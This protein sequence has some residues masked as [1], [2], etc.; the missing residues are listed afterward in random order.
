MSDREP[1]ISVIVAV[2]NGAKTLQRCIDS[3][4]QQTYP[5]KELIII[6]GGSQDGTVDILKA[7]QG[8]ITSWISEPDRGIYSAWNKGLAKE[9][10]S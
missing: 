9:N 2:L 7:N 3:V 10:L 1:S 4:A 6:D 5:N 8:K